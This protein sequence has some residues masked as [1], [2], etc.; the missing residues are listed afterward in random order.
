MEETSNVYLDYD[1][2]T[3]PLK[4]TY[5]YDLLPDS[6]TEEGKKNVLGVEAPIWTEWVETFDR[7]CYMC[8]PRL[9]AMAE[10][11]WTKRERKDYEDFKRRIEAHRDAL[12]AHGVKMAPQSDWDPA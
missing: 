2:K 3:T 4:K 8:F 5:S 12:A 10:V 9:A 7:L 1:Y 11:G 6:L